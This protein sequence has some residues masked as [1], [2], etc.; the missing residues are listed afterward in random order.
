V[1][2][3]QEKSHAWIYVVLIGAIVALMAAGVAMHQNEQDSATARAKAK[4]LTAALQAAG[5][6]APD[7][8]TAVA[9]FGSDGGRF[10]E[11]VGNAL[12]EAEFA[13]QSGNAGPAS[14]AVILDE[15]LRRAGSIILEVYAPQKL[16]AWE[17]FLSGLKLGETR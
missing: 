6:R 11:G 4:E 7:E 8:H 12:M 16:A 14:R 17:D 10:A 13:M 1:T 2:T 9:I 3:V 5:L 15:D